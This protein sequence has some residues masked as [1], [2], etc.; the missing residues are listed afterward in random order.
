MRPFLLRII[1]GSGLTALA[2]SALAQSSST[3]G[4]TAFPI[5]SVGLGA[6]AVGMGESFTAVAD[7]LSALQYN[8]AGLAQLTAPQM[9]LSHN[10]YLESGFYDSFGMALPLRDSGALGLGLRYL[11]Y[12]SLD[13]RDALGNLQGSYTPFDF[14]LEGAF[15]FDLEKHLSLGFSSRWIRQ[16]IDGNV[17]TGLVWEGG[18][19]A[20]PLERF[21]VGLS[22]KNLGVDSGGE[23][24]PADILAGA[25][26]LVGLS[27]GDAQSLLLSLG[28]DLSFQTVSRL[29]IGAEFANE[30]NFFLRAGYSQGLESNPSGDLKGLDLGAGIRLNPFQLDYAFSFQGELGNVHRFS[31]SIFLPGG[32]RNASTS[33][34]PQIPAGEASSPVPYFYSMPPEPKVGKP[35]VLKFQV[36]SDEDMTARE[37]FERGEEKL[38]MGLKAEALEYY[39]KAVDK[40]PQFEQAWMSL[41][42]I[43]FDKS[44]ESYRKA[45]EMDP[46]NEKLREWLG[47][48]KR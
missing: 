2:V 45:L 31:L 29:V 7:D 28:G 15:G 44:L 17:H 23:A 32:E 1:L 8:P 19:L 6:R 11:N 47:H 18:F 39:L 24:L 35:V 38:R 48:F 46:Q 10:S 27:P 42:K 20:H 21:S 14:N 26:Y 25:A 22:L 12:G 36:K 9:L 13:R 43:Y 40:D 34:A 37:M 3:I 4:S 30:K 5:L 16:D 33:Q 41:G